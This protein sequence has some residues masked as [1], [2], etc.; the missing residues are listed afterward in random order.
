M[1]NKSTSFIE[2]KS[3]LIQYFNDGIK[4]NT[5]LDDLISKIKKKLQN[6]FINYDHLL[7]TKSSNE[8]KQNIISTTIFR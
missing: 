5:N 2:N 8:K 7:D 4:K 3:Q 6:K 1:T